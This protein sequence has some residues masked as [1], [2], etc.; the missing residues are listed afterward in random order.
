MN[1]TV[2]LASVTLGLAMYLLAEG[3]LELILSFRLRPM[4]GSGWLLID[5]LITMILAV[6]IWKAWPSSAARAIGVLLG[7]SMLFS[8]VARLILSLAARRLVTVLA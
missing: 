4:L 1:L 5:G 6:M 3:V 7:I 2:G 8:G